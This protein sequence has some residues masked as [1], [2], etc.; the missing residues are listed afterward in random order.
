MDDTRWVDEHG[1][2]IDEDHRGLVYDVQTL[3]DRRR[4]LGLFGGVALTSLLAACGTEATATP[5]STSTATATATATPAAT[6]TPTPT[7][8]ADVPVTEIPDETAGPYPADGSNGVDVLDDSGIVRSDIRSSFGSS[9]TVAEGIPLSVALT[10]RD[11]ATGAALAGRGVYLWHCNRDGNYSL[12]SQG[13]EN[14]NYLRGVQETDANGVV[15]FTTI[16]P[17]CYSGRWPHIHF[18]VY[19]NLAGAIADGPIVKTSQLALP[20]E[21]NNAVYA[22]AGYEQSVRNLSEISLQSDNVFGDDGGIFQIA[23]MSGSVSEGYT[24]ALTVGV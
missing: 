15:R 4:V 10:I 9:T 5:T 16:Y 17:A 12:Y 13:L 20:A 2:E 6:A 3:I 7:A 11:A 23:T 22:T 8:T 21:T 14:E 1:Q 19:E 24:A 18:E